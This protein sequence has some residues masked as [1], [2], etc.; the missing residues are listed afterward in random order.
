[1]RRKVFFFRKIEIREPQVLEVASEAGL[2]DLASPVARDMISKWVM[3]DAAEIGLGPVTSLSI[4]HS[5]FGDLKDRRSAHR[6]RVSLAFNRLSGAVPREASAR[7]ARIAGGL[8]DIGTIAAWPVVA[9][10]MTLRIALV[11]ASQRRAVTLDLD[12][13]CIRDIASEMLL[14]MFEHYRGR[15][16]A[17]AALNSGGLN[18]YAK[19]NSCG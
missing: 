3:A 19:R 16:A 4:L 8:L 9:A 15:G 11:R 5:R 13:K 12:R 17:A 18:R 7:F 2:H 10:Y 14:S 1:M 6:N